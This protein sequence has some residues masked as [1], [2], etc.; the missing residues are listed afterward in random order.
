MRRR[1]YTRDCN[2]KRKKKSKRRGDGG[3]LRWI[4]G[5]KR[6]GPPCAHA[7]GNCA[8]RRKKETAVPMNINKITRRPYRLEMLQLARTTK[9]RPC[10]CVCVCVQADERERERG[11]REREILDMYKYIVEI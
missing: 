3:G 4:I 6:L 5:R 1:L 9:G 11:R 7:E 2:E 8:K 10:V